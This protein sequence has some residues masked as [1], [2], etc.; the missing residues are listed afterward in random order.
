MFIYICELLGVASV[1][2]R[3][4]VDFSADSDLMCG[5]IATAVDCLS[6]PVK[7]PLDGKTKHI[8]YVQLGSVHPKELPWPKSYYI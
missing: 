3:T 8:Q 1:F 7:K 2:I 5:H 6:D 4:G